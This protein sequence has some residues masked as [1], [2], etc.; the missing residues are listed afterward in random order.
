MT[1]MTGNETFSLMPQVEEY[2]TK[3][4]TNFAIVL[5]MKV[6]SAFNVL[7]PRS[8]CKAS[9]TFCNYFEELLPRRA[10]DNEIQVL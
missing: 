8:D 4:G 3:L 5:T 2:T 9:M 10:V 6:D 7:T 1:F